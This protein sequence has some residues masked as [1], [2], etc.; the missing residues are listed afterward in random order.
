[1]GGSIPGGNDLGS[2]RANYDDTSIGTTSDAGMFLRYCRV[3]KQNWASGQSSERLNL[4]LNL[5]QQVTRTGFEPVTK[6]LR[7][8]CSIILRA[9]IVV[10]SKQSRHW[11]VSLM[12]LLQILNE[13]NRIVVFRDLNIRMA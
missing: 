11:T 4:N 9:F 2:N 12:F 8:P 6:G 1:M 10:T 13:K 3:P 7:E 5:I